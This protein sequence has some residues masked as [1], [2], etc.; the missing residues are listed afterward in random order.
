M[1]TSLQI[2][3]LG[4]GTV[5]RQLTELLDTREVG[6]S[7]KW[8]LRRPGKAQGARMTDDI[9]QILNDPQVDVVVDVLAGAH[10]AYD[11][12]LR[13]LK[14]GKSVVSANKA[15]LAQDF[16]GLNRLAQSQGVTLLFEA[17]CGGGMPIVEAIKKTARFDQ[18]TALEGILNGTCN[19]ML[20]KMDAEGLAFDDVLREAQ[21]L[22]YAEAD[23][24]ADISGEDVRNKAIIACSLAYRTP[25]T[26][27]FPV[28]GIVGVTKDFFERLHAQGKTLRLMMLSRREADRYAI[29]VVP[30]VLAQNTIAASIKKN[31]NYAKWEGDV[32][33][34]LSLAGQGA[35]GLPTSDAIV[36]DLITRSRGVA[37][38]ALL[39][40]NLTY[41]P[42]LLRGRAY[43]GDTIEENLSLTDAIARAQSLQCFLAFEP[44]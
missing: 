8:I 5:G 35:G 38:P 1:S 16:S 7:I 28:S 24:T 39:D 11:Y 31:F 27:D 21:A 2:A 37:E 3:L 23:P 18:I 4:Y 14:A 22:G 26:R 25:V 17:A 19:F 20:D 34:A 30:V 43:L 15:A 32:V 41:D 40:H 36:Q 33:G 9:E 6:V 44:N 42:T 10:P 13:A 29:G 12:T